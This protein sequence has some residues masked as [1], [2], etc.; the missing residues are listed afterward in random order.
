[1][2]AQL[3]NRLV[4]VFGGSGFVGRHIVRRLAAQGAQVRIAVRDPEDALYLRT[5]GEVGQVVA[6][7]ADVTDP[8]SVRSALEGADMAVNLVGILSPWGKRTFE[9]VH[10]EGARNVATAAAAVGIQ[11]LVHMSAIADEATGS[12]YARTK[13]AA[14]KAVREAFPAAVIL[15]PSVIFGPE[16]DFFNRFA[17][18]ARFTPL[19]P[20]LG[21]PFPPK[22][23]LGALTGDEAPLVDLFGDGGTHMQPVYVGDV[24]DAA[25]KGLTDSATRGNTYELGGPRRYSYKELMELV[26]THTG[27]DRWLMPMHSLFMG[28]AAW[29]M[30]FLPKPMVTRDQLKL[31]GHDNVVSMGAKT[32]ADLGIE[33]TA[34]EG[35]LPGYLSRYKHPLH[36]R[37]RES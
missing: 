22:I 27:R 10:L 28:M 14:E 32:L 12:E 3:Q 1:M 34:A 33:P 9:K 29:F 24:A 20:V 21:C 13:V 17:T 15:K 26:I 18:L 7:P 8:A 16:D 5:C 25:I 2:V 23:N 36:Q 30:E 6:M 35:V 4:T 37:L 11:S 31:L 19:L